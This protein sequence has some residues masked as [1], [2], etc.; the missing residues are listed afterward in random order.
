MREAYDVIVVG[1]GPA[2][3][4]A[5]CHA[6]Q[7]GAKVLLLEKDRD[8][9]VPVR[10]A[11]GVGDA[12]L[13]L[14]VEP[15]PEWIYTKI[16]GVN[17]IA[18]NGMRV[19]LQDQKFGYVLNRK[20]F[21]NYLAEKAAR[22]GTE[23]RTKAYVDGLLFED[24]YVAGVTVQNLGKRYSI[25]A[26]IVIGADGVESRVGRWAGINTQLKLVDLETCV[27]VTMVN[28]EV[29]SHYCDFYFS[30][31]IAP[32]GYAWVFPKGEGIANIGLGV[33][34]EY[35]RQHSPLYYLNRFVEK[36]FPNGAILTT[37][38]GGVPVTATLKPLT[39]NGLMLVGDAAHQANPIS[40]GGIVSGMIAGRIA[41]MVAADAVQ[42]GDYSKSY[43]SRYER[44]WYKE[45]GNNH[46]IFYRLKQAVYKLTDDDLN[47][48]AEAVLKLPQPKRTIVNV[49]KAALINNPKLIIDAI[50]VFKDQTFAVFEPLT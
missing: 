46:K 19:R 32:G 48:T 42:E 6:A 43:L 20:I 29:D 44:R 9:G 35:A 28:V 13:R 41:G 24:N 21:D 47:R 3:S 26:K 45:E 1:A 22:A 31:Q 17:L 23:I 16:E 49:F 2:G 34:G 27:Q 36:Y 14:V 33:S 37:S 30:R 38:I 39:T 7:G 5:A 4:V 10:C 18:P 40:G 8:I 12:G 11:E 50:K 15:K 25:R